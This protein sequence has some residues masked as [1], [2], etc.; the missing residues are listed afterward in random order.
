MKE[1]Y[2]LDGQARPVPPV[3]HDYKVNSISKEGEYLVF[4][5]SYGGNCPSDELHNT[6][7]LTV[8]YHLID[9]VWF[10]FK[11]VKPGIL[12]F[13]EGA[14]KGLQQDDTFKLPNNNLEYLYHY[15][16]FTSII[17]ELYSNTRIV[18]KLDADYIE[19]EW[20]QVA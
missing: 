12:F 1:V 16:G 7:N 18:M 14:Y 19:Y 4:E 10:L 8:R 17:I 15:V 20:H 5:L 2:Y 6:K 9:E 11:F 3:P 13:K